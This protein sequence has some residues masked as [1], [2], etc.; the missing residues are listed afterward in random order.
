MD[1]ELFWK[2]LEPVHPMAAA[3]CQKLAGNRDEGND[4]YQ[5][6]LLR[7][8]RRI[9][10]LKDHAS[11]RPWLFR[12]IINSYKNRYR[13]FWHR[14]RVPATPDMI[15]SHGGIDPR[16]QYHSR[17]LLQHAMSVLT[18]DDKALVVLHEIE[19]WPTGKLAEMFGKPEGTIKNRIF[20]AKQAMRDK[21]EK[22]LP[23]P[24]HD[25]LNRRGFVC[26]AKKQDG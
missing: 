8:M 7:A 6:A 1:N 2:L 17:R 14:R 25:L 20:R 9:G 15:D 23:K 3:F 19:G 12:L 18:S 4:L 11:F 16:G 10:T 21:L 22:M 13:T 26:A 5:D 24:E